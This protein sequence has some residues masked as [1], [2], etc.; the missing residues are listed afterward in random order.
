MGRALGATFIRMR[1]R[2]QACCE[3]LNSFISES[4]SSYLDG[5]NT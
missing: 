2:P 1:S 3:I 5:K 4:V